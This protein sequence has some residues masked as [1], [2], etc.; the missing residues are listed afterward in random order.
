MKGL[1]CGAMALL[2][3]AGCSPNAR[4]PEGLA[5]VRVL[6]VDGRSPVTLTAVCGGSDQQEPP[7]GSCR[8][9]SFG[10]ARNRLP[11]SGETEL[12]LTSVSW[13]LIG[14]EGDLTAVLF[15]VLEDQE[16]G[17]SAGVYAADGQA[18]ELL[19][20]A[21]DP[22]SDLE[23]LERQ[24]VKAPSAAKT[25]GLL[26]TDGSVLLPLVTVREGRLEWG[27][28]VRLNGQ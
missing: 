14:A 28:E 9:E 26:K 20:Q 21:R 4:E 23:L 1:V 12:A 27:G 24:G 15:A 6:G 10:L 16:L 2:L 3:L 11:W 13:L 22:V 19:A 5:L 7:R 18:A 17:A 8:G 25:L